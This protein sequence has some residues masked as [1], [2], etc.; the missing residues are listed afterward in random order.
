MKILKFR[1]ADLVLSKITGVTR[2]YPISTGY[3]QCDWEF[4]F[5]VHL[6]GGGYIDFPI[7]SDDA[8]NRAE[9][10]DKAIAEKT[11]LLAMMQAANTNNMTTKEKSI[12]FVNGLADL[13]DKCDIDFI[14]LA[15]C[16]NDCTTDVEIFFNNTS[17][18]VIL[19][20]N[21]QTFNSDDLR[22]KLERT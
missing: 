1:G 7:K 10:R 11:R 14:H 19:Q 3:L 17:S 21:S 15:R 5:R 4:G 20:M 22:K 6:D 2:I 9:K 8:L 18:D 16:D 13:M 12:A